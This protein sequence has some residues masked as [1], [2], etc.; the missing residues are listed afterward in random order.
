LL[1]TEFRFSDSSIRRFVELTDGSLSAQAFEI[2]ISQLEKE[3]SK[4]YFNHNSEANLLR[5]FNSI[6][7]RS[8]FF[9]ELPRYPHH[10]EILIAIAASSYYL[11][12]I[13]V[14]HPEFL[15][16]LFDHDFLSTQLEYESL[17]NDLN[18]GLSN[19]NSFSSKLNHLRQFKQRF[20]LKIGINDILHF[21]ELI[22]TTKQLSFLA[23]VINDKLFQVCYDEILL[24]NNLQKPKNKYCL[25]SLGKL[26][27]DE[28]N[29]SSDVDL[30][31]F[32]DINT[33]FPNSKKDF[34]EILSETVQLFSKSSTDL[35]SN[36]YIYRVDFR[37]RP[38]GKYSPLCKALDDYIKYYETRGED[39]ERQMLIKLGFI[40]GDQWLFNKFVSFVIPYVYRNNYSSSIKDKIRM[41]KLNI[42]RQNS[43]T[44]DV[45]T[46]VG[47]IR[48]I[49]FTIQAL[50][51]LNGGKFAN[52]RTGNSLVAL[53]NLINHK[54]ISKTEKKI[55]TEAY[56]FYR[57]IEHF[58]Q[59][60]ND[61]QTHIIPDD[62][63][64]IEK[65]ATYLQLDSSI[66]FTD[67]LAMHRKNVRSV[68]DKILKSEPGSSKPGEEIKFID[69]SKAAKNLQF[70]RS[71][72]GIIE[73]KEFDSRTIDLFNS[74]EPLLY[75]FLLNS[76]VPDRVLENFV[77]I[78]RSSK[79]ISIWYGEFTN[80]KFFNSFLFLCQNNQKFVDLLAGSNT[81]GDYFLSRKVFVKN[82]NQ[83]FQEL[84]IAHILFALSAQFSLGL[85]DA[86]KVSKVLS[87]YVTFCI[88]NILAQKNLPYKIFIAGLGSYGASN[89]SFSSDVD[90]IVVAEDVNVD[91]RI[92]SHFQDFLY[93]AQQ[94]L[95]PLEVDF[96]LRPEGK[97]SQLVWDI[98]NYSN[99]LGKR[100]RVWEFQ[101]LSK[102]R[103][104]CGDKNLFA[105]F[106]KNVIKQIGALDSKSILTEIR[107][108]HQSY[109]K[110]NTTVLDNQVNVKKQK[111]GLTT[112]DF[113][114]QFLLLGNSNLLNKLKDAGYG[115][116][117]SLLKSI[118]P[119]EDIQSI[120]SGYKE[121]KNIDFSIQCLFN[122]SGGV[123][124]GQ[125]DKKNLLTTYLHHDSI[126]DF[127]T[128]V[129]SILKSNIH[130]FEK[131]IGA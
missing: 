25:C 73:R 21:D 96:R 68:Y 7:D 31:L 24:K 17:L 99:Y 118:I 105:A 26:G 20:I 5:I 102:L 91:D 126:G 88:S 43:G 83:E 44:S 65:L 27:G 71:G 69:K 72:Q 112:L 38:D 10:G 109:L 92:Q 70:L 49:E 11:T 106:R 84:S 4:Y 77:R 79:F 3:A 59:L 117:F 51:L 6:Y 18:N 104:V 103:F 16:Q 75:N 22:D 41:M 1:K 48:D 122:S 95:K 124:P 74:I 42:E 76:P 67:I 111:G 85:I 82:L 35:T 130:L 56:I 32:Y 66:M 58:L 128:K 55:F 9:R 52:L 119:A 87:G 30:I 46:F 2:V 115:K 93:K 100:A 121:L 60:M 108:M 33:G 23:K 110:Q 97:K 12:D 40:G 28:L 120:S 113:V 34:H 13:I 125:D 98:E 90:L 61:Q 54:L 19:Y 53:T 94:A 116:I 114:I 14:L 36:G 80:K 37:L 62:A 86:E 127:D 50:Q 89:M 81:L 78:I 57:R 107:S 45:K 123:I 15:Y 101:S 29:Y 8:F 47:G 129:K 131:Y 39:W 63:A 64:M